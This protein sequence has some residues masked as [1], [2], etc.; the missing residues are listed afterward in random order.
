MSFLWMC[1]YCRW[2]IP[3]YA[4]LEE[5]LSV[6]A[7]GQ[8]LQSYSIF[9]WIDDKEKAFTDLKLT[10]QTTPTLRLPNPD[11]P[12]T[13]AVDEKGGLHDIPVDTGFL[14]CL[15]ALAASDKTGIQGFS[16]IHPTHPADPKR[17][18]YDAISI[19][20]CFVGNA[21]HHFEKNVMFWTHLLFFQQKQ[22]V[23]NLSVYWQ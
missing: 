9:I 18:V 6:I 20:C 3:N 5:P 14:N 22:M 16:R 15:R 10:W 8:G 17:C 4:V 19:S 12:S 13:Q 2:L 11:R 7:H 21:K 1:L 23:N